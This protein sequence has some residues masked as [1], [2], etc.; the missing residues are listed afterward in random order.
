MS[1]RCLVHD[2]PERQLERRRKQVRVDP[3]E[4]RAG[5]TERAAQHRAN[6]FRDV[7]SLGGTHRARGLRGIG[8]VLHGISWFTPT[9]IPSNVSRQNAMNAPAGPFINGVVKVP[10]LVFWKLN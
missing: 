10:V 1:A 6:E 4:N 5:I 3:T 2:F 7:I 8:D 9:L